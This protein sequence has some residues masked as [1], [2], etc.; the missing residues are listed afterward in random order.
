[1]RDGCS[2]VDSIK[3]LDGLLG[4]SLQYLYDHFSRAAEAIPALS[5][6]FDTHFFITSRIYL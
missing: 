2:G 3:G 4:F 1:M 6:Y 5:D